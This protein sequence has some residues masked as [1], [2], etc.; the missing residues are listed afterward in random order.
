MSCVKVIESLHKEEGFTAA[1]GWEY[2]WWVKTL[3]VKQPKKK[4]DEQDTYVLTE[5]TL[6]YLVHKE[7]GMIVTCQKKEW[8]DTP[9]ICMWVELTLKAWLDDNE[10]PESRSGH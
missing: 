9:G 6:Q 10:C 7:K 2:K 1:D 8:M 3:P 4:G 5:F